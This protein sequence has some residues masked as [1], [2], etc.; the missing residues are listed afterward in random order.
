MQSSSETDKREATRMRN[1][2]S[3][4]GDIAEVLGVSRRT[5]YRHFAQS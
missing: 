5:L 4:I 3:T 2:G 1:Q